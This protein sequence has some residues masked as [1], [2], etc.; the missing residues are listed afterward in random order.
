MVLIKN[1]VK[2]EKKVS[3][4]KKQGKRGKK[5]KKEVKSHQIKGFGHA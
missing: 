5:E 4:K 1:K 3:F 2:M